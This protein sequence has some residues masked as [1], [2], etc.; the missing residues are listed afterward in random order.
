MLRVRKVKVDALGVYR[1]TIEAT[2]DGLRYEGPDIAEM[3]SIVEAITGSTDPKD[4]PGGM[5]G[6]LG[7]MCGPGVCNGYIGVGPLDPPLEVVRRMIA[8]EVAE[9]Q[10]RR[11]K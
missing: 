2:P 3:Q 4:M 7:Y 6:M 8:E 5:E 11:Q 10:R 1:G 9:Q